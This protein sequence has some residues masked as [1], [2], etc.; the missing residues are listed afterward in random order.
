MVR[1]LFKDIKDDLTDSFQ[2][3]KEEVT[4]IFREIKDVVSD[5][6]D[7]VRDTTL[8]FRNTTIDI[9]SI[10][11]HQDACNTIVRLNSGFP[12]AN[13][14]INYRNPYCE[15]PNHP[16]P[17]EPDNYTHCGRLFLHIAWAFI[18]IGHRFDPKTG[19]T[20]AINIPVSVEGFAAAFTKCHPG[21]D[22]AGVLDIPGGTGAFIGHQIGELLIE[23][24]EIETLAVN[25]GCQNINPPFGEYHLPTYVLNQRHYTIPGNAPPGTV[26]ALF[27]LITTS[28]FKPEL[29]SLESDV[30]GN[31]CRYPPKISPPPPPPP[32][33]SCCPNVQQN[34]QLLRLILKRIGEPKEVT[35]FDEDL[36][37]KGAQ[38][39]KK[40]PESLND[41]LKLAVERTE[42]VSRIV[43]IENFPITLPDT[44][45]EPH[46]EGAF[47]KIFKFID[48]EKKR[49]INTIAEF[50]AWMAEQDSAV[51]GEFHQVIEIE[52]GKDSK[53]K[54]TTST[55]VLPNVAES[56][57]EITL[58]VAQMAKQNNV[59]TEVLFKSLFEIVATR[60]EA[61]KG[62]AIV[63]DIQDY[64]DYPTETKSAEY[65]S[66]VNVPK[67]QVNK[68]GKAIATGATEDHKNLL[69]P[70]KVKFV[71]ENW[72]GDAS[73]RDQM[74]DLLQLAA[75]MRA[76]YYQR[77]DK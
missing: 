19:M 59:Q 1:Q 48:G 24:P 28:S 20:I 4:D 44:M 67:V 13:I 52:G 64:L 45:I 62:T 56:L 77:T 60:A 50:I 27:S 36:A 30:R 16:P 26:S 3:V 6:D 53:G 70:G 8:V 46:K 66:S 23:S 33:M 35:I 63:Q 74:I 22:T 32:P 69:K 58:L 76:V 7:I 10:N 41:F 11:V 42:I 25:G 29:I 37:R 72:T 17:F 15:L 68:E 9:P 73:L 5:V 71:H 54:A 39:A 47:A 55:V 31:A 38:K 61:T 12:G 65:G 57:R 2:D 14:S 51:L 40:K 21:Y 34:D 75:M 18:L 49:K 43:G